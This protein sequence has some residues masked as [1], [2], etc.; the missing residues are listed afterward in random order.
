MKDS[1]D[2][3]NLINPVFG[4]FGVKLKKAT[5]GEKGS[6]SDVASLLQKL[7]GDSVVGEAKLSALVSSLIDDKFKNLE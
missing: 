3:L 5:V 7:R 6:I 4:D 2:I 1:G